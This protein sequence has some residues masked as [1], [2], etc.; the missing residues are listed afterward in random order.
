MKLLVIAPEEDRAA[1][2]RL[3]EYIF[4]IFDRFFFWLNKEGPF[5]DTWESGY[6]RNVGD[7]NTSQQ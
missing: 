4:Q 6:N 2:G 5:R 7:F 1:L 3:Y